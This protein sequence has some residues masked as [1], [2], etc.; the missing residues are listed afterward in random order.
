MSTELQ[1]VGWV[2]EDDHVLRFSQV[3]PTVGVSIAVCLRHEAEQVL[4]ERVEL[5]RKTGDAFGMVPAGKL[6]YIPRLMAK[7]RRAIV[8]QLANELRLHLSEFSTHYGALE[9]SFRGSGFT[10]KHKVK[11]LV[12]AFTPS[13]QFIQLREHGAG[14]KIIVP[15]ITQISQIPKIL[16][17]L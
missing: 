15:R 12:L 2:Q 3:R 17:E 11:T 10:F 1:T 5:L 8:D 16:Q 14:A 6:M 13:G 9:E 4:N 7:S